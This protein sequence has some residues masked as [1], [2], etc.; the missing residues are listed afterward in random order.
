MSSYVEI[1]ALTLEM[2]CYWFLAL[3]TRLTIENMS[4]EVLQFFAEGRYQGAKE[5]TIYTRYRHIRTVMS[6][7]YNGVK[8]IIK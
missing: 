3:G 7:G 1:P 8:I 5:L 2:F 4:G 6:D